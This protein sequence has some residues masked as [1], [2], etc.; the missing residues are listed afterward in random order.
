MRCLGPFLSARQGSLS[1]S[2]Q[3]PQG[4]LPFG[5]QQNDPVQAAMEGPQG[6]E[7][8][9]NLRI[10]I[11]AVQVFVRAAPDVVA[12]VNQPRD[13]YQGAQPVEERT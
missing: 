6:V 3:P 9:I 12:I 5:V 10:K 4:L 2:R 11:L 7:I 1:N 13:V 8:E